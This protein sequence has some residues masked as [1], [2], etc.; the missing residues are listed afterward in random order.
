MFLFADPSL[1]EEDKIGM[2]TFSLIFDIL[3]RE[4]RG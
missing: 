2:S 4:K 3:R 1:E